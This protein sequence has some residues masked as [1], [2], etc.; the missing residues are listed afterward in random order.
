MATKILYVEDDRDVR[1]MLEELLAAEGYEVTA[2]ATAEEAIAEL[3]KVR[4]PLC[5]TDYNLP[6]KNADWLLRVAAQRGLLDD[7]AVIV[8]SGAI[9]PKGVEGHRLLQKPVDIELLL[10]T[11]GR[12]LA[13]HLDDRAGGAPAPEETAAVVLKLYFAGTSSESRRAIRNLRRA[14][15]KFDAAQIRLDIHDIAERCDQTAPLDEDRIVVTPTLVRKHP[16]PKLWILGDL[17][18]LVV[19]EDMIAASLAGTPAT[20]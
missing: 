5:L 2:F 18:N 7:T 3:E 17:S 20:P 1:V 16:S 9:D 19:V 4:Y 13:N 10:S 6:N 8:L 12:A 11:I 15:K 14:L